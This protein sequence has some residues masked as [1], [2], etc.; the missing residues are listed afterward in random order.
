MINFFITQAAAALFLAA[1]ATTPT[2]VDHSQSVDQEQTL[3]EVVTIGPNNPE[4]GPQTG[5]F[6]FR[7]VLY[8]KP[9]SNGDRVRQVE[10]YFSPVEETRDGFATLYTEQARSRYRVSVGVPALNPTGTNFKT[11]TDKIDLGTRSLD[12]PGGT[13]VLSEIRYNTR[14]DSIRFNGQTSSEVL[15]LGN[16]FIDV[17]G[18][19]SYCLTEETYAFDI[20][21]GETMFLGGMALNELPSNRARWSEH[22]PIIGVDNSLEL[23]SGPHA[24]NT[25]NIVPL[26]FDLLAFEAGPRLCSSRRYQTSALGPE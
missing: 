3:D 24:K 7:P 26:E 8:L 21:N 12:L 18:S 6:I 11:K 22:F 5:K 20:R 25:D 2:A 15:D 16:V 19:R 17:T 4:L 1:G 10:F 14:T 23:V 9:H 13:Y